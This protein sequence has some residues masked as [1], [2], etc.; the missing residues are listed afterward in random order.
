MSYTK[1]YAYRACSVW[2]VTLGLEAIF[3]ALGRYC[4]IRVR[5]I[6]LKDL[7]SDTTGDFDYAACFSHYD[8]HRVKSVYKGR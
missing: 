6:Q 5:T 7:W 4:P 1:L 2:Y 3:L 8:N